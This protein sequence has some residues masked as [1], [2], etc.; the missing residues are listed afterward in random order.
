MAADH[1]RRAMAPTTSRRFSV[2]RQLAETVVRPWA[3]ST[4]VR[5]TEP[6]GARRWND[7]FDDRRVVRVGATMRSRPVASALDAHG[8]PQRV[9]LEP[10]VAVDLRLPPRVSRCI[11]SSR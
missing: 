7:T 3:V 2:E 4:C 5:A 11:C 1:A 6:G 8:G 10:Q 9:D